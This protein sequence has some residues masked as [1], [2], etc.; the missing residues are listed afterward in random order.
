MSVRRGIVLEDFT[1]HQSEKLGPAVGQWE[2]W[3]ACR[4]EYC[5]SVLYSKVVMAVLV[6]STWKKHMWPEIIKPLDL[7]SVRPYSLC[8]QGIP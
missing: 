5:E 8:D 2:F 6:I 3:N 7:H 1:H 4:A